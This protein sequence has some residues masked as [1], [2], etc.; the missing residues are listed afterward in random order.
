MEFREPEGLRCPGSNQR[1]T[2]IEVINGAIV[3]AGKRLSVATPLNQ[4]MF[5]L[6]KALEATFPAVAGSRP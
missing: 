1:R 5:N 4:S 3:D 2:E 6:I